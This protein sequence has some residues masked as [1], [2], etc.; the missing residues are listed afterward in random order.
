VDAVV[1]AGPLC[2][3]WCGT[4]EELQ[5]L[6]CE[7]DYSNEARQLL[8]HSQTC[9]NYLGRLAKQKPLR[10]INQ[11]TEY[12]REWLIKPPGSSNDTMTPSF[13][14]ASGGNREEGTE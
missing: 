14:G 4:A 9:G 7:S 1:F 3:D 13:I 11:R 6:L 8:K 2:D 12:R 10:V 5:R